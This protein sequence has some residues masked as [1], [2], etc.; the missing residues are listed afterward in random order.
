MKSHKEISQRH[1]R[2]RRR[3]S[4]FTVNAR[5]EGGR[6]LI[7][8]LWWA[9][10]AN[11]NSLH[12]QLLLLLLNKF[13][14]IRYPVSPELT[15]SCMP[16][17]HL[18]ATN[19]KPRL[20]SNNRDWDTGR[21]AWYLIRTSH[22]GQ[23]EWNIMEGHS[24]FR[25]LQHR[26]FTIFTSHHHQ[27]PEPPTEPYNHYSISSRYVKSFSNICV[28]LLQY[29]VVTFATSHWLRSRL[30]AEVLLNTVTRKEGRLHL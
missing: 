29:I 7:K 20:F 17:H 11:S 10:K 25:M 27:Q 13:P 5:K 2:K 8:K 1:S 3:Q 4:S 15:L 23:Q 6:T 12:N 16:L 21:K 26:L 22:N 9:K 28:D 14:I 24:I 30:K 19:P 18:L